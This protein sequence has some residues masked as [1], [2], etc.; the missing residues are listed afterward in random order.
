MGE[1]IPEKKTIKEYIRNGKS[2]NVIRVYREMG[3]NQWNF[4][5]LFRS[6]LL[7]NY[8]ENGR[9]CRVTFYL[10]LEVN[11]GEVSL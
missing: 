10:P 1:I 3:L 6:P 2:R 4:G 11:V 9:I 5:A 8:T 7:L